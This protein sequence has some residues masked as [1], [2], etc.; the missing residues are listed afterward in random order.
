MFILNKA[1]WG[2]YCEIIYRKS[3]LILYILIKENASDISVLWWNYSNH[4][5]TSVWRIQKLAKDRIDNGILSK[6]FVFQ[7]GK[8]KVLC[9]KDLKQTFFIMTLLCMQVFM[10]KDCC[11]SSQIIKRVLQSCFI[12]WLK[13]K[14]LSTKDQTG[15][16]CWTLAWFHIP[17]SRMK[18]CMWFPK[19]ILSFHGN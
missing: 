8:N 4:S 10:S 11:A 6:Y 15:A 19:H 12:F 18:G 1:Q 17:L 16:I 5:N 7:M 14:F 3:V 2:M 13:C 9:C